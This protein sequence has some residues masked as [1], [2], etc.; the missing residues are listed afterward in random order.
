VTPNTPVVGIATG[1]EREQT[2]HNLSEAKARDAPVV[3][4]TTDPDAL[5][6]VSDH[7]LT[8]PDT[9]PELVN[10]LANVKLQLLSYHAAAMLDRPIDKPR[11]L[12]KSVTVE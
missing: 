3:S 4:V 10:L 7:T 8:L 9:H 2:T 6:E 12:A 1:E 5:A 11:N